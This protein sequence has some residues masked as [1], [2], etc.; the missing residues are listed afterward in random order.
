LSRITSIPLF[1]DQLSFR[2]DSRLSSKHTAF[3]RYSHDNSR[4]FGPGGLGGSANTYPSNWVRELTW[5]DQSLLGITSVLRP[6]LVN[7]FRL[8]YFFLSNK[9]L[10]PDEGDC[11]GCLGLGAPMISVI[12]AGRLSGNPRLLT[13]AGDFI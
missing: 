6:T 5:A 13:R 4:T 12:Q 11:P 3:L 7:D 2:L 8:S 9:Q 1:G 10:R